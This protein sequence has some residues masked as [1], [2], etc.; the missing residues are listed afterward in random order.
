MSLQ[1]NIAAEYDFFNGLL[2][3]LYQ[4]EG[5]TERAKR[6]FDQVRTLDPDFPIPDAPKDNNEPKKSEKKKKAG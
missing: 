1:R 3:Q 6:I 2:A 5:L 4:K